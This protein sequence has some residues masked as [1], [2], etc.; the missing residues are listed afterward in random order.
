MQNPGEDKDFQPLSYSEIARFRAVVLFP[1]DHALMT[2][3]ELYSMN[4]PIFIPSKSWLIRL[5]YS[6][7]DQLGGSSMFVDLNT[8]NASRY[9]SML[10][11]PF[12]FT[13]F[14]RRFYFLEF[15]D[16]AT[17]P[18]VVEFDNFDH[19]FVNLEDDETLETVT[20]D[21]K[22]DTEKRNLD[23]LYIWE[24]T[25]GS[26]LTQEDYRVYENMGDRYEIEV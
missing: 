22:Y 6:D 18:H 25:L 19:L 23:N 10:E 7:G 20:M 21:M 8:K 12:N 4:I 2:F 15:S 5:L 1:W 3:Y 24:K 11:F 17:F 26:R 9:E 14:D 13:S 16:I